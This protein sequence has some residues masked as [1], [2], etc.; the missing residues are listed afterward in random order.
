M[1]RSRKV[2]MDDGF[3]VAIERIAFKQK[4][5]EIVCSQGLTISSTTKTIKLKNE[6]K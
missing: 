5:K 4:T 3:C 2:E 6:M 1:W